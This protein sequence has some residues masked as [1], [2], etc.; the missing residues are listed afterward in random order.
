MTMS[1]SSDTNV[2]KEDWVVSK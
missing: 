2:D 1:V